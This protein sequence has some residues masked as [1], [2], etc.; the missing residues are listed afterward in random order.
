MHLYSSIYWL[1]L[2]PVKR[3]LRNYMLE[4]IQPTPPPSPKHP[5]FA[6][7]TVGIIMLAIACLGLIVT[8]I[9]ATAGWHYWRVATPIF[10]LLALWLSWY[11]RK[12]QHSLSPVKLW[13][14]LLHWVC[15]IA[16]VLIIS[17]LVK[18]G[19]IGRFE[20]SLCVLTLL[21]Q[22]VFL[23]GIYIE[24]TFLFVGIILGLF[25]L[26]VALIAE[27]LYAIAIP[28]LIAIIIAIIWMVWHARKTMK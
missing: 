23:A 18:I 2:N 20:A 25:A 7:V 21:A 8:D 5:W 17:I 13:H 10:A 15:L 6:R 14:E 1:C 22:S 9:H 19:I 16:T 3:Y 24:T 27:Y 28:I 4:E 12:N 26:G 11:L